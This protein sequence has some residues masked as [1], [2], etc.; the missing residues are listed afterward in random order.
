MKNTRKKKRRPR[1][2][3]PVVGDKGGVV[4]TAEEDEQSKIFK[5]LAGA[6]SLASLDDVVSTLRQANNDPNKVAE[7]LSMTSG[8]SAD[9]PSMTSSSSSSS[10]PSSGVSSSSSLEGLCGDWVHSETKGN[11]DVVL[12]FF[13]P[14]FSYF[15]LIPN[16]KNKNKKKSNKASFQTYLMATLTKL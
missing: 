2:S 10:S 1:V 8:Y 14:D 7:I 6:F 15:I 12:F 5:A 4:P 16:Y 3:N 9:D 13:F 11:D